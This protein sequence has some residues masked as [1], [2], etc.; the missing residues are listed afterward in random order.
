MKKIILILLAI[1]LSVGARSKE[2]RKQFKC[3][4]NYK[5][6]VAYYK[7]GRNSRAVSTLSNVRIECI[8]GISQPD[9]LYY[10]LGEAYLKGKK[11]NEALLEYQYIVESYPHSPFLEEA[12][13]KQAYCRFKAAPITERDSRMLRQAMRE[14]NKFLTYYPT[15]IWA[16]SAKIYVD[17]IYTR[18]IDKEIANAEFYEI[19]DKWDAAIIYYKSI[20]VDFPGNDKTDLINLQI[21]KDLVEAHRFAEAKEIIYDLAEKELY[22]DELKVINNRIE[23]IKEKKEKERK[24][25]EKKRKKQKKRDEQS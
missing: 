20:L 2:K 7:E 5:K 12:S 11:P 9:T 18:L 1:V 13:Y 19:I 24:R 22:I 10:Y 4:E 16:D 25:K 23:K 21:A 6:G 15:S 8:G 3:D 14:F 17:T